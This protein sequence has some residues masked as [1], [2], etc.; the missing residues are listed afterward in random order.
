MS[1]RKMNWDRV[2]TE[3]RIH[4][5]GSERV[6]SDKQYRDYLAEERRNNAEPSEGEFNGFWNSLSDE[7]KKALMNKLQKEH[8]AT[9][10]NQA[11]IKRFLETGFWNP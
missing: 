2:R 11:A 6:E 3:N 7:E 8:P 1:R 5:Q 10:R 9:E 4:D